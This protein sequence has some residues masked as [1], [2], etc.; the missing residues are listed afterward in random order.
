M[1]LQPDDCSAQRMR[2]GS[3]GGN[4]RGGMNR[5]GNTGKTFN[6]TKKIN[7]GNTYKPKT[8]RTYKNNGNINTNNV[9]KDNV[10]KDNVRKDNSGKDKIGNKDN[11][12]DGVSERDRDGNRNGDK[13]G[14]R[15]GE[16]GDG[17]RNNYFDN[18]TNIYH[19]YNYSGYHPYSYHSY[20]PYRWGA[21]WYP[22]GF[23]ML[24]LSSSAILLSGYNQPSYTNNYYY[25]Q[26]VYYTESKEK[27]GY[28]VVQAPEGAEIE[29]LPTG[30]T[31]TIAGN[32]TYY[33]FGGEFYLQTETGYKVV[34]AP[35]GAIIYNLPEGGEEVDSQG[36]KLVK[37]NGAYYHPILHD[38]KDAYE[39][40]KFKG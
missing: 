20:Y 34:K 33:Y 23:Y 12:R 11:K 39:V 37:Y 13:E 1:V 2:G 24:A 36:N 3:R 18:S 14:I 21:Y 29:S 26:G 28:T 40:V 35:L 25:D 16:R 22:V 6:N 32:M 4:N 17:N 5:S 15:D 38:G 7:G 8:D 10:R 30:Y 27:E 19:G 9:K 31:T